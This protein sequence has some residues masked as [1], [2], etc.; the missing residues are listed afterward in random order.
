MIEKTPN[1]PIFASIFGKAWP[2]MPPVMHDHYA[3]R[4]GTSDLVV[5]TGLMKI[6]MSPLAKILA[7]FFKLTGTLV[8]RAGD[9]V[10]VIVRF[11]ADEKTGYMCFDRQFTFEDG[12]QERFFSKMEPVGGNQIIEWTGSGVGWRAAFSYEHH[13]VLLCHKGYS[14]KIFGRIIA[15]P[16]SWLFGVGNASEQATSKKGFDMEMT[17]THPL[18][19]LIYGYEGHFEI[20]EISLDE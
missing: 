2:N 9:K 6:T 7:P 16:L 19:G 5:A 4:A 1:Q 12:K 8:P 13:K 20:T 18:W 3:I 14:F 17:L 10:Q 11:T 15:L